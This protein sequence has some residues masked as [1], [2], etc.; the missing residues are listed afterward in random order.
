MTPYRTKRRILPPADEDVF[1]QA[2]FR[3]KAVITGDITQVNLPKDE[4]SGLIEIRK[5]LANV[6]GVSLST[7]PK[8]MS[9][10]I[11]LVQQIIDAYEQYESQ[12]GRFS[13]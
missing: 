6:K 10:A 7:G 8:R 2:G 12:H 4:Y 1:N 5:I 11:P 3:S 13:G 9:S